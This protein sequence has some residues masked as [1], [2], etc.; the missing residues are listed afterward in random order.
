L[1]HSLY[2]KILSSQRLTALAMLKTML[3]VR[4]PLLFDRGIRDGEKSGFGIH[5][6]HP[7]FVSFLRI[8]CYKYFSYFFSVQCC[9]SGS[10]IRC[11]L[12]ILDPESG[13]HCTDYTPSGRIRKFFFGGG[14]AESVSLSFVVHLFI[15]IWEMSVKSSSFKFYERFS[16]TRQL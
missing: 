7:G 11:T 14:G 4:D 6:K 1:K 9:G 8:L 13:T 12:F 10:G 3:R 2:K 5:Y 16:F 15:D